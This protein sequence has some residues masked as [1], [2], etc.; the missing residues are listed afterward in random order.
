MPVFPDFRRGVYNIPYTVLNILGI[1]EPQS[2]ENY[3]D[4]REDKL[5]LILIDALGMNLFKKYHLE[6]MWSEYTVLTSLFPSTT[7]NVLTTLYTGLKPIEHGILEFRMFYEEYGGV[8]KTLPFTTEES[9]ENDLLLKMGY[10]PNKLFALPTI[11]QRLREEGMISAALIR[12]EYADASYTRFL[13][14][15]AEIVPYRDLHEAFLLLRKRNE[16]FVY[17]YLDYLDTTEHLYGVHSPE[18]REVLMEIVEEVEK[19][20]KSCDAMI[21]IAADHG[22]VDMEKIEVIPWNCPYPPGGSPRDLFIYSCAPPENMGTVLEKSELLQSGILG[23]GAGHPSIE[24]RVPD[25]I[26]LPPDSC[27]VW[28]RR[29]RACGLH[30]GLSEEEMLVP[31]VVLCEK[32]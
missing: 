32:S 20:R 4:L 1:Q 2:L 22:Q 8:I 12:S 30:G 5:I 6:D 17:L 29:F 7:A 10:S 25:Y 23:E 18:T 9:R 26:L 14:D 11:F 3:R 13:M 27:G 19:L 16:D 28:N 21:I 15:T 24:K 31:F